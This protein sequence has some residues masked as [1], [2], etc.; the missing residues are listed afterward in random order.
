MKKKIRIFLAILVLINLVVLCSAKSTEY[1]DL[2]WK[3]LSDGA[4]VF[5]H[6]DDL[7]NDGFKEVIAA[8]SKETMIGGSGWIYVFDREGNMTWK[9]DLPGPI[10]SILIDDLNNDGKKEIIVGIFSYVHVLDSDGI[11]EW[12]SRTDYRCKVISL[13]VDDLDNDGSK[14]LIV[15]ASSRTTGKLFVINENGGWEW[16]RPVN[17]EIHA[18]YAADLYKSGFKEIIAGTVGRR[19]MHYMQRIY[20]RVDLRRLLQEPLAGMVSLIILVIFRSSILVGV[21]SGNI[22]QRREF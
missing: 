4:V 8:A 11:E 2:K 18:L 14:E 10:S 20:T 19:F 6:V 9:Y 22:K 3:Y 12:K 1:L 13:F 5:V 16:V 21:R 17:G 7:D 15:G